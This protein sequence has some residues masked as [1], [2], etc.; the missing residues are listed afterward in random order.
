[1]QAFFSYF[2]WPFPRHNSQ[3]RF[4]CRGKAA[5]GLYGLWK[6][7]DFQSTP[8]IESV[9]MYLSPTIQGAPAGVRVFH[10]ENR[11]VFQLNAL[12]VVRRS[13]K[14]RIFARSNDVQRRR[15]DGE[16]GYNEASGLLRDYYYEN[17]LHR[18]RQ[19]FNLIP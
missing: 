6:R 7:Q 8:E 11:G 9:M 1:M 17:P 14:N 13:G 10:G 5:L 19:F 12:G 2:F 3:Q 15:R 4:P 18:A 16:S